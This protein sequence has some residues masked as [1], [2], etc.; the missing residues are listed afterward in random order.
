MANVLTTDKVALPMTVANGIWDTTQR[1][2]VVVALSQ[3]TP[4]LFGESNVMTFDTHPKAEYVGEGQAKANSE[5]EF[6]VRTVTP[7]KVQVTMRF[8]DEVLIA[9]ED[10]Q[11]G[12]LQKLA[13]A[14]GQSLARALDLGVIHGINPLTGQA[15]TSVKDPIINCS[16]VSSS[17][18]SKTDP[19][20]DIEAAAALLINEGYVPNG[21]ALD[22]K[23]AFKLVTSRYPDGRKKFPEIGISIDP[24]YVSGVRASVSDTVSAVNESKTIS[25]L[26]AVVG[27]WSHF[28]WGVQR[29]MGVEIIRYG[30]PDGKG[31]LARY[32]Q[33][34][35]RLEVIYGWAL[36]STKAFACVKQGE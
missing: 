8:S 24:T 31:D 6:G 25:N 11:L 9:D 23:F 16:H 34:A 19:E 10:Y 17:A 4:M 3:A 33:V 30:D 27:D 28:V 22:N 15:L 36:L 18:A 21:V 12:V 35:L 1:G 32:N 29:D 7:K 5:F 14:G 2:S 13:E 20:Q 26:L